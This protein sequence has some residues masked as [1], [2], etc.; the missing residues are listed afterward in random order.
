MKAVL[1]L[2]L[3]LV[4]TGWV[5]AMPSSFPAFSSGVIKGEGGGM[6]RIHGILLALDPLLLSIDLVVIE[7]YSFGAR[8]RAHQLGELGGVVRHALWEHGVDFVNIAP[9]VL[10]KFATGRGTAKKDQVR[11]AVYKCWRVEYETEHEI[12]AFVLAE[13]GCCLLGASGGPLNKDRRVALEKAKL[14][15]HGREKHKEGPSGA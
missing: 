5:R 12:D 8:N 4:S 14:S 3:G 9:T 13:I 10:K 6:G 1:G 15:Y 11:L 2:D 7:G